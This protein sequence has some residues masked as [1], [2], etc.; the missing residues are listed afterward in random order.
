MKK[1]NYPHSK[2][3]TLYTECI[4]K[5]IT[6]WPREFQPSVSGSIAAVNT[7]CGTEKNFAEIFCP[8]ISFYDL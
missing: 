6:K 2:H 4:E 7:K 8:Q 3:D 5:N 1:W